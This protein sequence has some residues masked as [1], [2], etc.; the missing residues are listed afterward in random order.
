MHLPLFVNK[1]GF[2]GKRHAPEL[3]IVGGILCAAASVA[4]AIIATTKLDK[5]VSPFNKEVDRI[6]KDMKDDYKI[7]NKI[8]DVKE[9]KKELT[10]TYLKAGL[11]VG[12]LYTPSILLFGA[13][14]SCI[15]GS[16]SIMKSRNLALTAACATLERSYKAYRDRVKAKIGEEAEEK[17]YKNIYKDEVEVVD[18]ETGEVTKKKTNVPHV[19]EDNDW[20]VMYDCGNNC[21]GR[22]ALQ[23]F[24]WLMMQ[25]TYLTEKLRRRGYLFLHE[26]Y[27]TLGCTT[28]QLGAKK[29]RASRI[30]G[31]IYDPSNPN[32]N[33]YV[34]FG[35]TQPGTLIP[36][37][38]VAEQIQRNEPAFFLT[39]NPDGDILSGEH[40]KETYMKFAK[41][42]A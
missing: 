32:R 33:C 12:A 40:G 30:L 42:W 6:K 29:A 24:D 22:D 19:K 39:L 9:S 27:D 35:L 25:Q 41:E 20:N 1:V 2:W 21:W 13:S 16:H 18:P 14:V 11:K 17:L 10:K 7:Q 37:P 15:L 4:T 8:V 38:A 34:S 5:T 36:L 28:A 23:N 26:V 3:L 31:W